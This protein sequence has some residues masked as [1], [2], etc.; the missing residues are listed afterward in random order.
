MKC[1]YCDKDTKVVDKRDT[2]P[3]IT[4]RRRECLSCNRRFTTYEKIHETNLFVIKKDNRR[5]QFNKE[6]LKI[7]IIKA[8]EKR[9]ISIEKIESLVSEIEKNLKDKNKKEI[10]S[11]EIGEFVMKKLKSLDK[12]AYIRFASVYREF[13]DVKDF[14]KE[15][16]MIKGG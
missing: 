5:E 11:T 10:R 1:P 15:V 12:V 9:P 8:C 2:A 14:E 4:R 7:G 13:K 16:D 6:K 3:E